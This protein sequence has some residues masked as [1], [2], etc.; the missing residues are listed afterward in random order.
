MFNLSKNAKIQSILDHAEGATDR[1]SSAIDMAGF[2]SVLIV[3]K[4][5][6]IA[7]G[8]TTSI[9][10]Q[11]SS[12]DGATDGYSD[13]AGTGQSVGAGDDNEIF[14]I[15][16]HRPEKRYLKLVVDKDTSN[17]TEEMAWAILYNAKDKPVTQPS[18]VNGE[19]H[20]SPSEGTA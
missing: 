5:G 11:Q 2:D 14:F 13:L 6:D 3:V 17:N 19:F 1:T 7:A 16:I 4:F 12:D 10:A 8:A 9:K 18:G 15:D 20:L